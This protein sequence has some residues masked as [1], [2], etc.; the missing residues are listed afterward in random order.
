MKVVQINERLVDFDDDAECIIATYGPMEDSAAT[1]MAIHLNHL[2]RSHRLS[3]G[4][5]SVLDARVADVTP[6]PASP[7]E[8][9][10]TLLQ[11]EI[12]PPGLTEDA[13]RGISE[14]QGDL[15]RAGFSE[16]QGLH[17]IDGTPAATQAGLPTG[18]EWVYA[19]PEV[20][21]PPGFVIGECNMPAPN[22]ERCD[23]DEDHVLGPDWETVR[24]SWEDIRGMRE[25]DPPKPRL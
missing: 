6:T 11:M 5:D 15:A 13:Q 3:R 4:F 24:H 19:G 23:R 20:P 14:L 16:S 10:L 12:V 1:G 25:G 21:L 9:L 22:D 17:G 2:I 8:A 18:T 7:R